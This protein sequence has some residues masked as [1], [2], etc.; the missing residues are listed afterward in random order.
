MF[1]FDKDNNVVVKPELLELEPFKKL[2]I[3]SGKDKSKVLKELAFIWYL[4]A[5]TKTNPYYI[6]DFKDNNAKIEMICTDTGMKVPDFTKDTTLQE[7]IDLFN[8]LNYN[9]IQDTINA[10]K[11]TKVK[12]K[13]Y[14][15]TYDPNDTEAD[16][17]S[18][19]RNISSMQQVDKLIKELEKS[20]IE[21]TDVSGEVWGG[22]ELGFD[23][24]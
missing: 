21:G 11:Q 6:Q 5:D 9:E 18:F 24:E 7:C 10:M 4:C 20:I 15:R 12:F 1:D 8:K 19:G 22:G 2:W 17:L 13:E 14:F 23:E 3:R 16:A